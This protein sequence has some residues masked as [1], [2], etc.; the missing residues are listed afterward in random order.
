MT[1]ISAIGRRVLCGLIHLYQWV[2]SPFFAGSCRYIP[3]C[4]HY[5]LEAVERHGAARGAWLSVRRLSRCHPWGRQ[6]LDPVPDPPAMSGPK[7]HHTS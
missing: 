6:G 1:A 5:A 4:S 3:S 7:R 2:I